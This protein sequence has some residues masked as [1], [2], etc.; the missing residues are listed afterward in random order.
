MIF[1]SVSVSSPCH[2]KPNYEVSVDVV[3]EHLTI[4]IQVI[5]KENEINKLQGTLDVTKSLV[6]EFRNKVWLVAS[7]GPKGGGME[8]LC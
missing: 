6:D 5:V 8:T 3:N 4:E 1:L 2:R 7:L